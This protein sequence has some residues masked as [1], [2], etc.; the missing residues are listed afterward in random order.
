MK[1]RDELLVGFTILTALAVVVGGAIW[2]SDRQ[3]GQSGQT[4][5]ARFRTVGGLST[6]TPVV[7]RGV[8]VGRVIAIALG[9]DDWVEASLEIR[10]IY[11]TTLPPSPAVIA[12]SASLFGEWQASIVGQASADITDPNVLRDLAEAAALGGDAWPGATLPDIGQLT[13]QAG[14]IASDIGAFSNRIQTAFDDEAVAHL[15]SSIRDFGQVAERINE[16][17]DQ[18]TSILGEVASN[19]R[20]TS[21]VVTQTAEMLQRIMARLDTATAAAELD[22][23]IGNTQ[24]V[25][26]DLRLAMNDFRGFMAMVGSNSR[27]LERIMVG[28]DTI[29]TRLTEGQGTVGRLMSDSTL[30]VEASRAIGELRELLADIRENPRK[31]FKFSVF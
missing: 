19:V 31:Y 21:D 16:F 26:A 27:S 7:L 5:F 9:E 15:Q 11:E 12:A 13:A 1:R 4:Y 14:R 23:I 22:S 10:S 2:L 20:V 8:Q 18:Q 30:Y 25:S 3:L 6:G 28:A 24:R 29:V 17:A